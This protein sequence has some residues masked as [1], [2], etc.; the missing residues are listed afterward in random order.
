MNAATI[1][2]LIQQA[3][4]LL[5]AGRLADARAMYLQVC[6]LE[7]GHAD[8]HFMLGAIAAESGQATVAEQELRTA[9]TTDPTHADAHLHLADLL[10]KQGKHREALVHAQ[11]AVDQDDEYAEAWLLLGWLQSL[12]GDL[13]SAETSSRRAAA[14]WPDNV[15]VHLN[16]G[17][18]LRSLG[19][20]SEAESAFRRVLELQ[21]NHTAGLTGLAQIQLAQGCLREA[22]ES[23][24]TVLAAQP[25]NAEAWLIKGVARAQQQ[26]LTQARDCFRTALTHKPGDAAALINLGNALLG[27]EDTVEAETVF[28][29]ALQVN[30]GQPDAL[31]GLADALNRAGRHQEALDAAETGHRAQP[32]HAHCQLMLASVLAELGCDK[33]AESHFQALLKQN[34]KL[35]AGHA[36]L[37]QLY[38]RQGRIDAAVSHQREALRLAPTNPQ[39]YCCLAT[40]LKMQ[41]HL[42]EAMQTCEQALALARD[43]PAAINRQASILEQQGKFREALAKL[44][45]LLGADP[46]DPGTAL[47]F[48][49]LSPHVDRVAD[50][51][52]VLEAQLASGALTERRQDK[53]HKLLSKL[54]DRSGDY[55]RAFSHSTRAHALRSTRFDA[56]RH[57]AEVDAIITALDA[58]ALARVSGPGDPSERPIFIVGM[59][60]SGTSLVEQILASHP[61]VF[62]AGELPDLPELAARLAAAT[63]SD[64]HFP[65]RLP[66]ASETQLQAQARRYLETLA[67]LDKEAARVTDK[68]PHNFLYLGVI[69]ALFPNAR[70]VHIRRNP[71]DTCLSCY[72]Q[73]FSSGHAYAYD[74]THLGRYYRAYKRVMEHWRR[75]L[76]VALMEIDYEDLI[77]DQ[78]RVSRALVAFCDLPWDDRCLRFHETRRTVTTPSYDQVRRPVYDSSIARWRNY[79]PWLGPLREA[80]GEASETTSL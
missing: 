33:E 78:E 40:G 79:E 67:T 66:E 59:P 55:Q 77:Q 17:D 13:T 42:E 69:Q 80:L 16:L 32:D 48:A 76:R 11:Q 14:L 19:R 9:L 60:R 53:M 51:I 61:D 1:R 43:L 70:V 3:D 65:T 27:L 47:A 6:D 58:A 25:S 36:Q 44:E 5:E 45:P 73:D 15:Q 23:A 8:A 50:G 68:L 41:G 26:D 34:P 7:P 63:A 30:P 56:D 10:A 21:P 49:R 75:T 12:G 39:L 46:I 72:L 31:A 4:T 18:A 29:E 57:D 2:N 74:L 52:A 28:I 64:S 20:L 62:G 71:M 54:Y 22:A 38:Q 24:S 35:V 37:A